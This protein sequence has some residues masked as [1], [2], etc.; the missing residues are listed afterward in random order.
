MEGFDNLNLGLNHYNS[1]IEINADGNNDNSIPS[2]PVMGDIDINKPSVT[3]YQRNNNEI[4]L[5]NNNN[6]Q[7]IEEVNSITTTKEMTNKKETP[8]I[9]N[10]VSTVS[11]ECSLNLRELALKLNNAE[12]NPRRIN[13]LIIRIKKPKTA[14]LVFSNGKMVVVGANNELDSKTAAKKYA[15]DI[16]NIINKEVKFKDF[17]IQ[18]VVGSCG[19]GFKITLSLLN[20]KLSLNNSQ[21]CSYEPELFPG[22]I[23]HM[24][25]P[26]ICLLIF[27]SGKIV[28][29]GA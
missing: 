6:N 1:N 12:Y 2:T 29:V 10:I 27:E 4:I 14:A 3:Y 9:V 7:Q 5:S 21:N 24:Q 18:N 23:Y 13:A 25:K 15:H 16:K 26:K 8:R 17:K 22:L 20:P 19:V 11:L 28:L